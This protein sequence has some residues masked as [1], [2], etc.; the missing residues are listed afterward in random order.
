LSSFHFRFFFSDLL[1]NLGLSFDLVGAGVLCKPLIKLL[2]SASLFL[3]FAHFL[4]QLAL[5]GNV[6]I[7]G[8]TLPHQPKMIENQV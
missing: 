1:D 4:F 7:G 3:K 8:E 2:L 5:I 6:V